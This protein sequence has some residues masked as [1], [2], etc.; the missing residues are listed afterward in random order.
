MMIELKMSELN[1]AARCLKALKSKRLGTSMNPVVEKT[2]FIKDTIRALLEKK[3]S[4]E[5]LEKSIQEEFK[6]FG[7]RSRTQAGYH[8]A[9]AFRQITRYVNSEEKLARKPYYPAPRQIT[10]IQGLKVTVKADVVFWRSG[11]DANGKP[12]TFAEAVIYKTGKPSFT[13]A[14]ANHGDA[15]AMQ[16]Y[17]LMKYLRTFLKKGE[18]THLK[19]SVYWLRK[20]TD[21]PASLSELTDE[22]NTEVFDEDFFNNKGGLNIVS[23]EETWI[24]DELVAG[25]KQCWDNIFRPAC[26]RFAKGL[27]ENECT[28]ADCEYCPY[29]AACKYI[30]PVVHTNETCAARHLPDLDL[31]EE[32]EAIIMIEKG[33][34]RVNAGAG[35]GKTL[36]VALLIANLIANGCEPEAVLAITFT[37]SAADELRERVRLYISDLGCD[38]EYA[39]RIRIMTFNAFGYEL[40]KKDYTKLGFTAEPK[41]VDAVETFRIIA[42]ILNSH[43]EIPGLDYRNFTSTFRNSKGALLVAAD[44]FDVIKSGNYGYGDEELI[45]SDFKEKNG[46][47]I[48]ASVV[49]DLMGLYDEFD[50][51]LRREN[52]IR[53]A[54][55]L[56]KLA[57]L[58]YQDPFYLEKLG[59]KH[60]LVDEFQ[61]TN[62][63]QLE[64]I[65]K[66][67]KTSSCMSLTVV[68]DD[69]Q[70]IYG[71]NG[72]SPEFIIRFAEYMSD[73]GEVEDHF[74]MKNFRSQ[75]NILDF[76]NAINALNVFRVPKDLVAA[77][78]AGEQVRVV[79]FF[80]QEREYR[81]Y[82]F[83]VERIEKHLSE[84]VRPEDI[85]VLCAEKNELQRIG[86]MLAEKGIQAVMMFPQSVKENSRVQAGLAMIKALNDPADSQSLFTYAS[87]MTEGGLVGKPEKEADE[88]MAAAIVKLNSV[89]ENPSEEGK[90]ARIVELLKELDRNEDEIYKQFIDTVEFKPTLEKITEYASDMEDF[91]DNAQAKC[92]KEYPGIVLT[93]AHSSKGLEWPIVFNLI[94]RY[95][96]EKIRNRTDL[97]EERRRLLFVTATRPRDIL[98]IVSNAHCPKD[99]NKKREE[100]DNVVHY[101]QF[102]M[103]AMTIVQGRRISAVEMAQWDSAYAAGKMKAAALEKAKAKAAAKSGSDA[104]KKAA[105]AKKA[106]ASSEVSAENAAKVAHATAWAKRRGKRYGR[107]YR[108]QMV[109]RKRR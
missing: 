16:L 109:E 62:R 11:H 92:S 84:G 103:E 64:L 66:M 104:A 12:M 42:D 74:L 1:S 70:S 49:T 8:A 29:K 18:N 47:R 30:L 82:K 32:Q 53:F 95:D 63:Q 35:S 31:T 68:G 101:N 10:L 94:T 79:P 43:P 41:V 44:V 105:P 100:Q 102:L 76:A 46:Y 97:T 37:V 5:E 99:K 56:T 83:I 3:M 23:L 33:L 50:C 86:S 88:A 77:K 61:D 21:R 4:R 73:I 80:S 107:K 93:T 75:K 90:K 15:K 39:D 57:E 45:I 22:S 98:Y 87:A 96:S 6:K 65:R 13:Q 38:P 60:I 106:T 69:S 71:F 52:L 7:Y 67:C 72:T 91:G 36:V 78:P 81:E 27:D 51:Y 85:A 59:L 9:D 2:V 54:D 108:Y 58:I 55:Q 14:A 28:A 48:R 17:A 34:H 24:D 89:R 26:V 19:A 25:K 20:N 40:I